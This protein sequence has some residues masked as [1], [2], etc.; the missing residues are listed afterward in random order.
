MG[1]TLFSKGFRTFFFAAGIFSLLSMSAWLLI[2]TGWH[3][4][5]LPGMRAGQWHAHEMIYGYAMAVIAGFLLTTVRNWTGIPTLQG[6]VLAATLGLWSIARVAFCIGGRFIIIAAIADML[7]AVMLVL[8]CGVP[9]VR[10]RQWRQMAI[11]SKL[12]LL[13][14]GNALFYLGA[15]GVLYDRSMHWGLYGAFYVV[16]AL[17]LTMMRR[18][19]PAFTES[20]LRP[21]PPLRNALWLDLSSLVLL[22][23]F[24]IAEVFLLWYDVA[25]VASA[26]MFLVNARRLGFWYTSGIWRRPLLWSMHLSFALITLGFLLRALTSVF[27]IPPTLA[28]HTFAIGGIGLIT[29]SMMARV[30]LGHTG[31]NVQAPPRVAS[32]M[33]VLLLVA[34]ALRVLGPL[35]YPAAYNEW[36]VAAQITWILAFAIFAV[37]WLPMLARPRIDGAPG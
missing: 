32:P 29:L 22:L 4:P 35:A 10:A 19:I 28:L 14:I 15:F 5:D 11:L 3:H 26:L 33:F 17:I 37:V 30:S 21:S 8:G 2:W 31:R 6:S 23:V 9:L 12:V 18:V 7:F 25:A 34:T 13:G 27:P 1:I 16:I 36:V 24:W 20:A